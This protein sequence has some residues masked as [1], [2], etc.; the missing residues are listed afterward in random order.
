VLA[1]A[2]KRMEI[3]SEAAVAAGKAATLPTIADE[4]NMTLLGFLTFMDTPKVSDLM[5][6]G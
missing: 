1:V 5:D 4:S 6:M 2:E 3:P